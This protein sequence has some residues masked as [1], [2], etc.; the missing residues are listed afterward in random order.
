MHPGFQG[1]T[2]NR[3]VG[4]GIF[5]LGGGGIKIGETAIRED[6]AEQTHGNEITDC[7]IHNGGRFFHS[8]IGVWIGQSGDNT[9]THNDIADLFYTGISVGWRWG[10]SNS[11][12][13]RKRVHSVIIP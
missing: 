1:C 8:A 10:Y 9:V 6:E 4:C 12:A 5:D 2:N 3:I 11:L 13:K 7:H